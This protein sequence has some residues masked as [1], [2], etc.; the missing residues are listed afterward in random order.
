MVPPWLDRS[1]QAL[2]IVLQI[3]LAGSAVAVLVVGTLM[4]VNMN[5][6]ERSQGGAFYLGIGMVV[7]LAVIVGKLVTVRSRHKPR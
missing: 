4:I 3:L 2:V 7:L 5:E 1:E 6:S